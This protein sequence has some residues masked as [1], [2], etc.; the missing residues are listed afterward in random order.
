MAPPDDAQR[1]IM[2]HLEALRLDMASLHE[3]IDA[4]TARL[5]DAIEGDDEAIH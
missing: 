2:E 4:L 1:R 5:E 3:K